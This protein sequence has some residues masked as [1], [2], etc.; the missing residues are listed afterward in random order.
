MLATFCVVW[1]FQACPGWGLCTRAVRLC[2]FFNIS[3]SVNFIL[4]AEYTSH[5]AGA[6]Y[7]YFLCLAVLILCL[8]ALIP[9][10]TS[11][12]ETYSYEYVSHSTIFP[13]PPTL[14]FRSCR[15]C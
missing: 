10:C 13:S 12:K 4:L 1:L 2:V 14:A 5:N 3:C 8:S 15:Y 7:L 11:S 6:R 9:E